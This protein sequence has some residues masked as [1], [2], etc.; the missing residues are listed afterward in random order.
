VTVT[1]VIRYRAKPERADENERLIRDVFAELAVSQPAG[2]RYA[3]FRLA[4]GVSFIHVAVLDGDV[5]PLVDSPAFGTFQSNIGDRL[6]DGPDASDATVVSS[7][8]FLSP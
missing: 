1:K 5:N 7:Y 3:T 8:R 2:L 6:V 4:D